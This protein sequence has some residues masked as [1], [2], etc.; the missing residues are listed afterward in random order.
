MG[1]DQ[2][3]YHVKPSILDP[4]Y[5]GNEIMYWRKDWNLQHYINT[6]NNERQYLD[7]ER[8]NNILLNL[9]S[10]YGD[11]DNSYLENTRKAFNKAKQLLLQK[12]RVLYYANW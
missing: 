7:L 6:E 2:Y 4:F 3:L 11:T 1:L 10:I 12:E 5:I 8:V 9:S